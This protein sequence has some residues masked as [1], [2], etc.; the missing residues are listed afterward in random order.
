VLVTAEWMTPKFM[1]EPPKGMKCTLCQVINWVCE[2]SL[3]TGRS[4]PLRSGRRTM[5]TVQQA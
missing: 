5:P 1:G 4:L 3:G 2:T